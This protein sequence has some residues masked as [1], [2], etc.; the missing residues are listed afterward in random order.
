[1]FLRRYYFEAVAGAQ[2][3]ITMAIIIPLVILPKQAVW[4]NPR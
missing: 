2:L 1:M 4:T 3:L